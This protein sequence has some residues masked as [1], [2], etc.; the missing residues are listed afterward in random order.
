MVT[1]KVLSRV[2]SSINHEHALSLGVEPPQRRLTPIPTL[3]LVPST[4]RN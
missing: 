1:T 3:P 2:S 4:D